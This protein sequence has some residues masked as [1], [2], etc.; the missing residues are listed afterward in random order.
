MVEI[1]II[2]KL[3]VKFYLFSLPFNGKYIFIRIYQHYLFIWRK[4]SHWLTVDG[5]TVTSRGNHCRLMGDERAP[6]VYYLVPMFVIVALSLWIFIPIL[7]S[8]KN[9][10]LKKYFRVV[11]RQTFAFDMAFQIL[12]KNQVPFQERGIWLMFCNVHREMWIWIFTKN[13]GLYPTRMCYF[14]LRNILRIVL[15]AN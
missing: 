6:R 9:N 12:V 7:F 11:I 1:S 2:N 13:T 5:S 10:P 8:C 15:H 3:S 14:F 4:I